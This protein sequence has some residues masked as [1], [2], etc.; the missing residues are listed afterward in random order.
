MPKFIA[1]RVNEVVEKHDEHWRQLC[2]AVV[3][4][5]GLTL[6]DGTGTMIGM[7]HNG[8]FVSVV[9]PDGLSD[10]QCAA[11]S[12]ELTF[13]FSRVIEMDRRNRAFLT[14]DNV[15]RIDR[16]IRE[17]ESVASQAVEHLERVAKVA[18]TAEEVREAVATWGPRVLVVWRALTALAG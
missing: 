9:T 5:R 6:R 10:D 1:V 18:N 2:A 11:L 12:A 7:G 14:L 16:G 13:E 17:A 15:E 8:G 3:Y 4:R